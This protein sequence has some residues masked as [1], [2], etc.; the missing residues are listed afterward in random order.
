MPYTHLSYENFQDRRLRKAFKHADMFLHDTYG[1]FKTLPP[2]DGDGGGGNFSI[3][4]VLLCIIDGLATEVWPG[5]AGQPRQPGWRLCAKRRDRV[6][7]DDQEKRFKHLIREKLWWGPEGKGRWLDRGNAADQLY[8]EFRNPLVHELAKDKAARSRPT[9]F[10]EPMIGKWGAIP[11][12]MQDIAV[13]DA[14]PKWDDAWPVMF[15]TED[16]QGRRRYKL[17]AAGLYWAVKQ[18]AKDMA[19]MAQTP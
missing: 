6:P 5:R 2:K 17:A 1:M 12:S 10:E 11:E 7:K 18:L 9:G 19:V 4:L 16:D 13:I 14:L 15:E 3:V 8:T